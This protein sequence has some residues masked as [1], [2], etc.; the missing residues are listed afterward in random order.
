ML[1]SSTIEDSA[2]ASGIPSGTSSSM[3]ALA[4]SGTRVAQLAVTFGMSQVTIYHWLKQERVDR[5]EEGSGRTSQQLAVS[6]E[7]HQVSGEYQQPL[8]LLRARAGA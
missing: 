3:I 6:R 4:R 1:N 7:L 8:E 5:G 2:H